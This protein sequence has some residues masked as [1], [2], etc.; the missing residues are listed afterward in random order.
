MRRAAS[1]TLLHHFP[2]AITALILLVSGAALLVKLARVSDRLVAPCDI[3][4]TMAKP[5]RVGAT[6]RGPQTERPQPVL[7]GLPPGGGGRVVTM[8]G[9]MPLSFE[10]NQGQTNER[11]K[12]YSRTRG[13]TL[14][15]TGDSAVLAFRSA[16]QTSKGK[17]QKAKMEERLPSLVHPFDWMT[18]N[19]SR[20]TDALVPSRF[21]IPKS[22]I[23]NLPATSSQ[24]PAPSVVSLKLVGA[25]PKAKVTGL[26]E[27]PGKSNYFLGNDPKKWRTNVSQYA[28]VKY[29]GVYPGID[30]VYYGNQQ[31]LEY[32]FVVAPGADPH[33]IRFAVENGNS[34]TEDRKTRID[35]NGDLVISTEGGDLRFHKPVV[36]QTNSI[37]HRSS[38]SNHQFISGHYIL[39]ADNQVSFDVGAY[40]RTRPLVIDPF[41]AYAALL[42]G[43]DIDIASA[44]D[45]DSAGN[46]YF[47]GNTYSWD[48]PIVNPIQSG[49]DC[50]GLGVC[51]Y[52]D[53]FVTKINPEGT[54]IIYS[55]YL[56]GGLDDYGDG[57]TV[58]ALG[59]TYVGG[60]TNS[61][62]FPLK[63]P[64]QQLFGGGLCFAGGLA[65]TPDSP[66][67]D[68]FV[69]KLDATGSHLV[70]AT[71]LGGNRNDAVGGIAADALGGAVV[72]GVTYSPNFPT[73]AG[74]FDTTCGVD[75]NCNG[76][77]SSDLFVSKLS[78]DGSLLAYSTFLGGSGGQSGGGIRLDSDGN[79]YVTGQSDSDDFPTTA[80]AFQMV[81]SAGRDVFVTKL[82]PFGSDLVYSTFLGGGGDDWAGG[83]AIDSTGNTYLTGGTSSSDFPVVNAFQSYLNGPSDV[84]VSKLNPEGTNLIY[85]TYLGGLYD[86][87]A[88]GIDVDQFGNASITGQT[89]SKD[90][91]LMNPIQ[92]ACLS[93]SL[94]D[95]YYGFVSQLNA[96]GNALVF[97]T[98]FGGTGTGVAADILGNTYVSAYNYNQ[99][100]LMTVGNFNLL[101]DNNGMFHG[102]MFD[103][104]IVKYS[105]G[106]APQVGVSQISVTFPDQGLGT[107]S[108]PYPVVLG[109]FASVPMIITSIDFV[110]DDP[111]TQSEDFTVDPDG[112]I[113]T[114]AVGE[115]CTVYVSFTPT[116]G[117][118]A[119]S[120]L[121]AATGGRS[122]RALISKP[123]GP[124]LLVAQHSRRTGTLHISA[125]LSAATAVARP[126]ELRRAAT[127]TSQQEQI[128]LQ[129]DAVLGYDSVDRA[130]L[131]FEPQQVGT[132]SQG[133]SVTLTN[134]TDDLALSV[135]SVTVSEGFGQTN[136]CGSTFP[137]SIPVSGNCTFQ[138]TFTPAAA[139]PRNGT[140]TIVTNAVDSPHVISL[141][142]TGTDFVVEIPSSENS[143]T[144]S[145][146]QTATYRLQLAPT[147]FSGN[148]AFGCAFQGSTPRGASCWVSPSSL[149]V[150]GVDAAP[151]TVSASTTA[152]SLAGPRGPALPPASNP[153]ARRIA[154]LL[155][156]IVLLMLA[157]AVER[158]RPARIPALRC[159]PLGAA[160][161]L[162]LLWAAC[163]GGGSPPPPPPTGTPIGTYTL[164]VSATANGVSKASSLTLKVN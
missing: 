62:D 137:I 77:T 39:T 53:A 89:F 68:G 50:S 9:R 101:L 5:E 58:D 78:S 114:Y 15:L 125:S 147:G 92:T 86:D 8:L 96:S 82:N 115:R 59:N 88:A 127:L 11:V 75:A 43:S 162:V 36:F 60:A 28:K 71:Y 18:D 51:I 52:T 79:A 126:D 61:S 95:C 46:A 100:F 65:G 164:T 112:C 2:I 106:L 161:L 146:G 29:Q 27:L 22:Q 141:S 12:F 6:N 38:I 87:S 32:D 41:V 30:L 150:N 104:L 85:S 120:A 144:V 20:T 76:L 122:L 102:G 119:S 57:I 121:E 130:S 107:T 103:A 1:S 156:G 73:T 56:G 37:N 48:F 69:A 80:G 49:P 108:D 42:G 160:M 157:V 135:A 90:F 4:N 7:V 23:E 19:R 148:V 54:A 163:G 93:G 40:D 3:N 159:A 47:T 105:P 124:P 74:A 133:Q 31:Q 26:D 55:T 64:L 128:P 35:E 139:G 94:F 17:G 151:F 21:Q 117:T 70:Y 154:P 25:N 67:N 142:G 136:T 109:N 143:K 149:T 13:Y 63:N 99:S 123:P 152:R 84:F 83:I 72:A 113:K 34:K 132:T 10:A 131:T 153:W 66:C 140:L 134:M 33:A 110:P 98:Y 16:S 129:G 155:L 158:H 116:T 118:L 44:V 24:P 91:P 111:D 81:K 45:V 138:V 14:F 97:S 145:A